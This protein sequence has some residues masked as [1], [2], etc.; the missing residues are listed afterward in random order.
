[1]V[2]SLKELGYTI[3][4]GDIVGRPK[5][6]LKITK[7]KFLTVDVTVEDVTMYEL[8]RNDRSKIPECELT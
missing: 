1:V 5:G 4:E 8:I 6:T 2:S 7:D 3:I